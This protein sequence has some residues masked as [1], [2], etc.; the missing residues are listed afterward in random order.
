MGNIGIPKVWWS[1]V[2]GDYNVMI[3]DLEGPS[4]ED[5]FKFCYSKFTVETV[6]YLGIQMIERIEVL[7]KHGFIHRDIKP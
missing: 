3:T 2:E 4:L 5:C 6:A 7:H 1:G